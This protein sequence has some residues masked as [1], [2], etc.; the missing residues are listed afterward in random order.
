[1]HG[2]A[3][4]AVF[5]SSASHEAE[6]ADRVCAALRA[7]GVK[8][9][10]DRDDLVGGDVAARVRDRFREPQGAIEPACDRPATG[11]ADDIYWMTSAGG[12]VRRIDGRRRG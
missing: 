9:W 1:M 3:G 10:F 4:G 12:T 5:L 8:V 11:T 6:D 2:S 7:A